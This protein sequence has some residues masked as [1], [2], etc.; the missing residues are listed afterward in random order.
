MGTTPITASNLRL[1]RSYAKTKL[2]KLVRNYLDILDGKLDLDFF[3]RRI[4][5]EPNR[6]TLIIR[7]RI[8]LE[9]AACVCLPRSC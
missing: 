6:F 2:A 8:L 9:F 1:R 5:N 7:F 4:P 3:H